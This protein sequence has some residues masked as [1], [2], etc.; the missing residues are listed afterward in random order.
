MTLRQLSVVTAMVVLFGSTLLARQSTTG[1]LPFAFNVPFSYDSARTYSILV[2]D[3]DGSILTIFD[4]PTGV[5]MTVT[6]TP[7]PGPFVSHNPRMWV[8]TVMIRVNGRGRNFAR[9]WKNVTV[10]IEGSIE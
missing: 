5:A 3:S 1:E 8:G 9:R 7:K 6:G 2:Q 4:V 10:L